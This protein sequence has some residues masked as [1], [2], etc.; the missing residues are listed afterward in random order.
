MKKVIKGF[1]IMTLSALMSCALAQDYLCP[2]DESSACSTPDSCDCVVGQPAVSDAKIYCPSEN[3]RRCMV[4]S[5]S[6]KTC[7]DSDVLPTTI[8]HCLAG[9][10]T[11]DSGQVCAVLPGAAS[12]DL[13]AYTCY[14]TDQCISTGPDGIL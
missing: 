4:V 3:S 11:S 1:V 9:L 10:Y 13:C 8:G 5:A 7:P 14:S 6:A 2:T 12:P